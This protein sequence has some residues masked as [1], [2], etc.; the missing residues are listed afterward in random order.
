MPVSGVPPAA[1]VATAGGREAARADLARARTCEPAWRVPEDV[2]PVPSAPP[3]P[4]AG[5]TTAAGAASGGLTAVWS[6]EET[7]ETLSVLPAFD[8]MMSYEKTRKVSADDA[9]RQS[10]ATM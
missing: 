8:A 1:A 7:S 6:M 10:C 2:A 9:D 5:G 3:K 4:G